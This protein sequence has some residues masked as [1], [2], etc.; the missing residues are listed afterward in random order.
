VNEAGD[1]LATQDDYILLYPAFTTRDTPSHVCQ[2]GR[3]DRQILAYLGLERE[4]NVA[5]QF[6]PEGQVVVARGR[7]LLHWGRADLEQGR[8]HFTVYEAPDGSVIE[9]HK[10]GGQY[11][12]AGLTPLKFALE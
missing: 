7:Y 12:L 1:V 9:A 3:I 2:V 8:Q 11:A 5:A 6:G 10:A 4:P